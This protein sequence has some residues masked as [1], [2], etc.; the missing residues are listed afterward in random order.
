ML[1]GQV[2]SF[3]DIQTLVHKGEAWSTVRSRV[4]QWHALD[5]Q[6]GKQ[7]RN[8]QA[9]RKVSPASLYLVAY[10]DKGAII[11]TT[12]FKKENA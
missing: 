1:L 3:E 4:T 6:T 11:P 7:I 8:E 12:C 5:L 9:F 2:R 10:S